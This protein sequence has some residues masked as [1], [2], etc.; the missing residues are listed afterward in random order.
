MKESQNEDNRNFD[1]A[2][3]LWCELADLAD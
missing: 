1:F 2:E 3:A